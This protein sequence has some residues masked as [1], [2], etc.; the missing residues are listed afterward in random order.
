MSAVPSYRGMHN[1]Y[2]DRE[3]VLGAA[4]LSRLRSTSVMA[5]P[6]SLGCPCIEPAQADG[7]REP[8]W[9]SSS[10][11]PPA[12]GKAA[13]RAWTGALKAPAPKKWSG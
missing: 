5:V 1:A 4:M 11:V 2:R 10:P 8:F 9:M 6:L 13:S 12:W 3:T 7:N